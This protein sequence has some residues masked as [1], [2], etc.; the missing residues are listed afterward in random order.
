MF[1]KKKKP[2]IDLRDLEDMYAFCE[3]CG[4]KNVWLTKLIMNLF[5]TRTGLQKT[6]TSWTCGKH[7]QYKFES[8]Y[9]GDSYPDDADDA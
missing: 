5:D 4:G 8:A 7:R 9:K 6:Y 3:G 1:D 2:Q